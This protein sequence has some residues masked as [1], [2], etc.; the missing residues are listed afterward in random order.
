MSMAVSYTVAESTC[1]PAVSVSVSVV[2]V[3]AALLQAYIINT[4]RQN[5]KMRFIQVTSCIIP[6]KIVPTAVSD[7]IREIASLRIFS[8]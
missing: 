4:G 6:G 3:V 7:P 1:T 8:P 5:S 2:A